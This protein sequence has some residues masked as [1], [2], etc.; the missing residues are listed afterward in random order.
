MN[1]L[2]E[3]GLRTLALRTRDRPRSVNADFCEPNGF[4]A[5]PD[6]AIYVSNYSVSG[7][8]GQVVRVDQ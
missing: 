7:G 4:A 6:G 2:R 5:G 1:T 8:N 3:H